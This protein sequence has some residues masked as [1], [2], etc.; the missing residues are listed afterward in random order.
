MDMIAIDI[1]DAKFDKVTVNNFVEILGS[2]ITLEMVA[3]N[4]TLGHYELMTGIGRR[5]NKIYNLRA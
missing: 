5:Y 2:N 4:S 3:E 1:T